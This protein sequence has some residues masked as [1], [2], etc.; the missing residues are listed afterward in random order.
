MWLHTNDWRCPMQPRSV[1]SWWEAALWIGRAGIPSDEISMWNI[2]MYCIIRKLHLVK[3]E[4]ISIYQIWTLYLYGVY[5]IIWNI[6]IETANHQYVAWP[7]GVLNRLGGHMLQRRTIV[8][9]ISLGHLSISL[10]AMLNFRSY[11]EVIISFPSGLNLIL[12]RVISLFKFNVSLWESS[13]ISLTIMYNGLPV[14]CASLLEIN[15][16]LHFSLY[17]NRFYCWNKI[18]FK[19]NWIAFIKK[20]QWNIKIFLKVHRFFNVVRLSLPA[21]NWDW[22]CCSETKGAVGTW[23]TCA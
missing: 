6:F 7:C 21:L 17:V 10:R 3:T 2:M 16:N 15:P 1:Q 20:W 18:N 22:A 13:M 23:Y 12:M 4:F 5:F 8:S 14:E 9:F 19:K 11:K